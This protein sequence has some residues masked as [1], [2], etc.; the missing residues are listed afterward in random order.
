MGWCEREGEELKSKLL[1]IIKEPNLKEK[2][3]KLLQYA[4][5]DVA[6]EMIKD[7]EAKI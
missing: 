7:V 5:K 4:Q 3:E 6:R 1:S 2:S